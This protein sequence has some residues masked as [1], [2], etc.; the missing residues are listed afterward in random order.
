[1][2]NCYRIMFKKLPTATVRVNT[3]NYHVMASYR[4]VI[5]LY[6]LK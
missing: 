1:M 3:E 6:I 4:Y 2:F 5:L